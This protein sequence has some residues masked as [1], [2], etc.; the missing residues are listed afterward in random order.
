M[1]NTSHRIIGLVPI[2]ALML[3]TAAWSQ[4]A[5]FAGNGGASFGGAIGKG[6][7]AVTDDG[8]TLTFVLT[9]G[10]GGLNDGL[11]IYLDSK[12]GGF[13]TTE[14]FDDKEDEGRKAISGFDGTH[15]SVVNFTAGFEADY[16][17]SVASNYAE[18]FALS[19]TGPH[20]WVE[21]GNIKPKGDGNA[22]K[23]TFAFKRAS[24]D[25]APGPIKLSTTY[26]NPKDGYRSNEVVGNTLT[27]ASADDNKNFGYN[28]VQ[29]TFVTV[30]PTK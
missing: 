4:D 19:Q 30:K 11:V 27:G 13:S 1:K 15:R 22:A 23:F 6:S 17:I 12:K 25:A 24:L 10:A 16:A 29:A 9:R 28:P 8:T 26:V 18:L 2:L 5:P 3:P 14:T 20:N 7:L 21:S